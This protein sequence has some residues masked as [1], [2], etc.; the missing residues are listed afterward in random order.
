MST[1]PLT[2]LPS[3]AWARSPQT[4]EYQE[5]RDLRSRVRDRVAVQKTKQAERVFSKGAALL[6][7][8]N[9]QL[10]AE[11]FQEAIRRRPCHPRSHFLLSKCLSSMGASKI[12]ASLA[13]CRT[14]IF[15]A[16]RNPDH[17]KEECADYLVHLATTLLH[18]PKLA[19][20][21]KRLLRSDEA[22]AAYEQAVSLVP[23]KAKYHFKWA[24][25]LEEFSS[26]EAEVDQAFSEAERVA[27][28]EDAPWCDP[29]W[30]PA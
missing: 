30:C 23:H 14:A 2:H 10:A 27:A 12:E 9:V 20:T 17:C 1:R 16:N 19:G 11:A 6:G 28:I 8:G 25:F 3:A 4:S 13:S 24:E 22:G 18:I 7:D 29:S 5:D 15:L 21:P 26:S